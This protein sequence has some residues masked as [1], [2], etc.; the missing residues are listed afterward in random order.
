MV[1]PTSSRAIAFRLLSD[2]CGSDRRYKALCSSFE[3]YPTTWIARTY[4]CRPM[5]ATTHPT[6]NDSLGPDPNASH[7]LSDVS[8]HQLTSVLDATQ[9]LSSGLLLSQYHFEHQVPKTTGSCVRIR[10]EVRRKER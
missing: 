6:R 2:V 5:L 3:K 7:L 10:R 9:R 4:S 8:S 1:R